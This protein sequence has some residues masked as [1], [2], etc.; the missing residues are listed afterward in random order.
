[1]PEHDEPDL[2][3]G[4]KAQTSHLAR[5]VHL[6]TIGS[7]GRVEA[8]EDSQRVITAKV[9]ISADPRAP[10][11]LRGVVNICEP[12]GVGVAGF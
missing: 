8:T 12:D 4:R 11:A 10:G 2:R 6:A 9:R 1:M 7:Y 5:E 3:A